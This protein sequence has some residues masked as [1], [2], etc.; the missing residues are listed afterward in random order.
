MAKNIPD[1]LSLKAGVLEETANLSHTYPKAFARTYEQMISSGPH[2]AITCLRKNPCQNCQ[3]PDFRRQVV[4]IRENL[5]LSSI[6]NQELL[7]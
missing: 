4:L 7:P 3:D 6:L 5:L 1:I 2:A